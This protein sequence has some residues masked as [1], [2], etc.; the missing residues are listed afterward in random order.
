MEIALVTIFVMLIAWTCYVMS[1]SQGNEEF[2]C[3][4]CRFNDPE[5]CLKVERP[6]AI[7]CTS[8]RDKQT[9]VSESEFKR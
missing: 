8:Y 3:G 5:Q 4:D 2:L 1:I 9:P 6:R 7:L